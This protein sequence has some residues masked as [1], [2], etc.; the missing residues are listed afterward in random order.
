M[1]SC[2][3]CHKLPLSVRFFIS[4]KLFLT[5][6][7][8]CKL[9]KFQLKLKVACW[10]TEMK[11]G[12]FRYVWIKG[13]KQIRATG[14]SLSVTSSLPLFWFFLSR[15]GLVLHLV[16]HGNNKVRGSSRLT[17]Y[18]QI[19]ISKGET[20]CQ[21]PYHFSRNDWSCLGHVSSPRPITVAQEMG[22]FE[23]TLWIT[24]PSLWRGSWDLLIDR[25]KRITQNWR[26]GVF[27]CK[28]C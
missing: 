10:I 14:I 19:A 7:F 24:S 5:D 6:S 2:L 1:Y 17:W 13:F 12:K 11:S 22:Y 16:L 20:L 25:L 15:F 26:G 9:K 3:G 21:H 18:W 4:F 28:K 23:W 27:C 8:G